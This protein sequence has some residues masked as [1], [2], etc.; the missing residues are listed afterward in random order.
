MLPWSSPD[1]DLCA[2]PETRW[3]AGPG[4]EGDVTWEKRTGGVEGPV[5]YALQPLAGNLV[6]N[7]ARHFE[8]WLA[9]M[10]RSAF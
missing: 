8:R 2:F 1:V 3:S 5:L 6:E 9:S 10:L 7:K 4:A